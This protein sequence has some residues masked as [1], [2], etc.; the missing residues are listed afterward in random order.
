MEN[1]WAWAIV[2]ITGA[3]TA[4][5]VMLVAL[6]ATVSWYHRPSSM[7][8]LVLRLLQKLLGGG[9]VSPRLDNK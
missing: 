2:G 1:I 4:S 9:A 8:F 5:A 7:K 6:A 3:V